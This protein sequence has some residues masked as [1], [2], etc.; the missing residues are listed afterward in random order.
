M[1]LFNFCGNTRRRVTPNVASMSEEITE[2]GIGRAK[3]R[4]IV[5]LAKAS[6]EGAR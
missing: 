2:T 3:V 1:V 6:A 5:I 4:D